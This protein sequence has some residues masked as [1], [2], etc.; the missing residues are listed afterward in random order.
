[1]EYILL[2]RVTFYYQKQNFFIIEQ[3]G[4]GNEN[5]P[6]LRVIIYIDINQSSRVREA[7]EVPIDDHITSLH[8]NQTALKKS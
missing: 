6:L 7:K 1:M 5:I 4:V 2:K 3:N 8:R